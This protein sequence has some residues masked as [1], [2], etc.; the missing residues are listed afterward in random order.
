VPGLTRWMVKTSLV[1]LLLTFLVG[2]VQVSA[3]WLP[4]TARPALA[5]IEPVRVH[6]LVIGWLTFLIFGVV[7]WMFPK[8]S[9]ERPRGFETLG[10]IT[11]VLLNLGLVLRILGE[12]FIQPGGGLL[13]LSAL[14]QWLA[15]VAFVANTWNRVKEK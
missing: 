4:A 13:V 15:S 11:Y 12:S 14:F 7:F 8:Y 6:L 9:R 1:Y 3:A 2:L 10:W 5:G